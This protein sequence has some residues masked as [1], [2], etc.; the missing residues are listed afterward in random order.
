[1][2]LEEKA[3]LAVPL[4]ALWDAIDSY[5]TE[6]EKKLRGDGAAPSFETTAYFKVPFLQAAELIRGRRV[7]LRGGAAYVPRKSTVAIIANRFSAYLKHALVVAN[8]ALPALL[9]DER[10]EPILK[11]M[12]TAYTGPEY[13]AKKGAAGEVRPESIDEL[14]GTTFALCMQNLQE[15]LKGASHLKHWGRQQYGLFLKGIGL[16]LEDALFFWQKHFTRK[17]SP[18]EFLKKYAYNIRHNYGKEGKRADYTPFSCTR[19]IMGNAPGPDDAHGCPFRHWDAGR[20]R[21]V[22][23]RQKVPPTAADEIMGKVRSHDY[24]VACRLHFEARFAGAD[25]GA[26]GNHPNAYFEQA[27]AWVKAKAGPAAPETPAAAASPPAPLVM[28]S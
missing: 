11:S 2:S 21:A 20:L 12:A 5:E 18:E 1:M 14:S 25:S 24:Q 9:A 8:K 3:E 23:D 26:I 19:I 16:S 22:L 27:V 10:L 7:L 6:E 17:M 28:G 4:R 15:T 13:G